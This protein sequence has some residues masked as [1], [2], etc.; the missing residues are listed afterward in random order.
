M[1][2]TTR[3]SVGAVLVNCRA[4]RCGLPEDVPEEQDRNVQ[5]TVSYFVDC[6]NWRVGEQRLRQALHLIGH[7][8][9][10]VQLVPVTTE[11]E[12][13]VVGFAGS[14]TFT[15][16]GVHVF[17]PPPSL[18]SLVCRVYRTPSGLAGV[19]EAHDLKAALTQKA[20]S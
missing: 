1:R 19:P 4:R 9:A 3:L 18:G 8:D 12:A 20:M 5:V 7:G 17:D 13:D 6:L 11:A 2:A 16:D 15:V 10:D 14:P